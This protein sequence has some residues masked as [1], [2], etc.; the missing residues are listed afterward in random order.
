MQEKSLSI[1]RWQPSHIGVDMRMIEREIQDMLN[2]YPGLTYQRKQEGDIFQGSIEICHNETNSNVILTGEF[3]MK[4]VIDDGYPQKIPAVYDV[5]DSIK[6]DYIHRYS[7]GELCL[8]SGIRLQLFAGKHSQK[9]F[10]DFFLINYLC[11]YLYYDRYLVYPNGE[12]PHGFWGE[13]DF[14]LE[15]F[16]LTIDKVVSILRYTLFYGIKRNDLCP[17]GSGRLVKRCHGK[18]MIELING[19]KK[20]GV[21]KIYFELL[22]YL[23]EKCK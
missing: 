21:E 5:N 10:I 19:I 12:R 15:Y 9:E 23:K 6:S 4:I 16:N 2:A 17:C 1:S 3:G 20:A 18:K 11:S 14:L 13:Y 22:N 7:N 8:E